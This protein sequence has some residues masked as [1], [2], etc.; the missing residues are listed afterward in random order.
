MTW[1]SQYSSLADMA[2]PVYKP[3]WHGYL[4][5]QAWLTWLSQYT[6]LADMAIPV[7]SLA[8]MAIPV[9]KPSWHGYPSIQAD[10]GAFM[11]M[12]KHLTDLYTQEHNVGIG[13]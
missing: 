6:S 7:Y 8:D 1:L 4:S 11:F 13:V 3:S 12:S 9:Y 5:I 2:I 10:M